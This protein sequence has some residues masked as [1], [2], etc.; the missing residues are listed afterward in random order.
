MAVKRRPSYLTEMP[1][2]ALKTPILLPV[3]TNNI[4]F[5]VEYVAAMLS[6]IIVKYTYPGDI[7]HFIT[8]YTLLGFMH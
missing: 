4:R 3:S 7:E 8:M 6:R 5:C 2:L 1:G